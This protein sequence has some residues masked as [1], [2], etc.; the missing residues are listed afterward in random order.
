MGVLGPGASLGE[1]ALLGLLH[2]RTATVQ[3]VQVR[4][5]VLHVG[6]FGV[7]G[8]GR[9]RKSD[10]N[11]EISMLLCF[12]VWWADFGWKLREGTWGHV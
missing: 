6:F 11:P 3:A 2:V 9:G 12:Y 8:V 5:P 7:G 4:H 10:L 1:A